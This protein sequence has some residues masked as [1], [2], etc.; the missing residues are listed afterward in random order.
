MLECL[1]AVDFSQNVFDE[2]SNSDLTTLLRC[3]NRICR[4]ITIYV[5]S[6]D[7]R[8]VNKDV[9]TTLYIID[10]RAKLPPY[11]LQTALRNR[12]SL[13]DWSTWCMMLQQDET[14]N[15]WQYRVKDFISQFTVENVMEFHC[16]SDKSIKLVTKYIV[17][18]VPYELR[19]TDRKYDDE[20][21]IIERYTRILR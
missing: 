13:I 16:M 10:R 8:I 7:K 11:I 2:L 1:L 18:I 15:F 21:V 9:F 3:S 17:A 14:E 20:E 6:L 5:S 19:Y 4:I 12:F